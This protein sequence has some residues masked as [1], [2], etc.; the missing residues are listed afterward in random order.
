MKRKKRGPWALIYL[1]L[2]MAIGTLSCMTSALDA[3]NDNVQQQ[4]HWS[5]QLTLCSTRS[6][7]STPYIMSYWYQ[8]VP[9]HCE[10]FFQG[11][12]FLKYTYN[13]FWDKW[14]LWLPNIE[15]VL[16]TCS[17]SVSMVMFSTTSCFRF[18]GHFQTSGTTG[19]KVLEHYK[20]K[21][22]H[23]CPRTLSWSS[24]RTLDFRP[25]GPRFE[26]RCIQVWITFI[27][28]ARSVAHKTL[29]VQRR[30]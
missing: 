25:L 16:H 24:G 1:C 29:A 7:Y 2:T 10:S 9:L 23:V 28:G 8:R 30:R 27:L 26:T 17:T 20:V 19:P 4:V 22:P 5:A 6:K 18:V 13:T 15:K 14:T 3:L 11:Q 12:P 21:L